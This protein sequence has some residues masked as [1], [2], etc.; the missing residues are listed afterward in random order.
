MKRSLASAL[1][2]IAALALAGWAEAPGG[3]LP[4]GAHPDGRRILPP[5]PAVGSATWQAEQAQFEATR[6]L[7]GSPRWAQ[8]I[9]D[10]DLFGEEVFRGFSCAAGVRLDPTTTPT[11]AKM[12]LRLIHDGRPIY[13]P[14]KDFYARKRPAVGNTAPICVPREPW[15]ETN[16]SYPSGHAMIGYSWSLILAE[17]APDRATELIIRG[18]DF[19]DSRAICG[20]HWQSD[21]E[22]G[23]TLATALVARLHADPGFMAD[24]ATSRAEVEAAR[25]LGAP[26]GCPGA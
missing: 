24:M 10:T 26:E 18:R 14:S 23:R 1:L 2:V 3:Y 15:I 13:N 25:K 11:L 5:P 4:D 16:G 7:E 19:G 22:A 8:A 12:L 9:R 6:A 21:V 17:L 20:V